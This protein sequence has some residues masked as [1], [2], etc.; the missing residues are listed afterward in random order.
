MSDKTEEPT[1][2]RLRKAREEG[3]APVSGALSQGVGFLV[4]TLIVPG[5]VAAV[6]ASAAALLRGALLD[7]LR[8]LE[9]EE[10]VVWVL[11][12]SLPLLGAVAIAAGAAAAV[13]AGGSVA[14]GKLAP[15]LQ[16]LD[17]LAGLRG[18]LGWQ[19]LAGV[20]RT[21]VAALLVGWLAVDLALER[22]ADLAR[23]A[24]DAT[25]GAAIAWDACLRLLR[26]AALV[27]LALGLLDLLL[28]RRAWIARLRMSKDEVRREF[29]ETE[30]DPELKAA[31]HRAHQEMLRGA[32][33]AAVRDAT[34]LVVNPTRL[35]TALCWREQQDEAPRVVAQGEGELAQKM[36]E[37][38]RAWGV[39]IVRDIPVARALRELEVGDEIPEAL[40][41][42]VAEVL[43]EA[44]ESSE[45]E[46]GAASNQQP[47]GS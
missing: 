11:T 29:R 44:W 26:I 34:V 15:Q 18:L 1:P 21:L 22:A 45:G 7:P 46:R 37:A 43:R 41:E 4:G 25:A 39:P 13:Q 36:V 14:L 8:P 19:R 35:A 33:I 40:Y 16:R 28:V 23:A 24:G 42:A 12:L 3:D 17:P 9:P 2:R 20:A 31:R 5:A 38:A 6:V 47:P 27:G 32:T 30:G 10:I